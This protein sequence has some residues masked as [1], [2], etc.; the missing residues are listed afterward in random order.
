MTAMSS[1]SSPNNATEKQLE[2]R[3]IMIDTQAT[4]T[5][6]NVNESFG[7]IA[8]PARIM[9]S[10]PTLSG[11]SEFVMK[12]VEHRKLLFTRPFDR[13]IYSHPA[14]TT[15][16]NYLT[17]MQDLFRD[18]E[19]VKGLPNFRKLNLLDAT[20]EKLVIIDD[21]I[22]ELGNSKDILS[23]FLRHSH[24]SRISIV[25][26]TQN[27][28]FPSTFGVTLRRNLSEFVVFFQKGDLL[29]L[30]N[31]S[32]TMFL[33]K[34]FLTECFHFLDMEYAGVFMHYL[35]IDANTQSS[36]PKKLQCRSMIFPDSDGKVIPIFFFPKT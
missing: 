35:V 14:D 22:M 4:T 23:T 1:I 19:I 33:S 18:L 24:H 15:N 5:F 12:M 34:N 11:K 6:L 9:I 31:L 27:A 36:L 8:I 32:R 21:Q 17:R 20:E 28:Y 13:I 25:F 16:E 2:D 29:G 10:G 3:S 7:K 26:T 30:Q